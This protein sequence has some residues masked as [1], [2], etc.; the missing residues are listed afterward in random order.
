ML[1]VSGGRYTLLAANIERQAFGVCFEFASDIASARR[2]NPDGS[3]TVLRPEGAM[4]RDSLGQFGVGVYE[5]RS[6]HGPH[7]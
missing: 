6:R 4:F 2:L 7:E 5:I 3:R 1:K